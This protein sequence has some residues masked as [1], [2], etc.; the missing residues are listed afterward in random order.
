M[1]VVLVL[2]PH[3]PPSIPI[4]MENEYTMETNFML[5]IFFYAFRHKNSRGAGF[6]FYIYIDK[7]KKKKRTQESSEAKRDEML[8]F[9]DLALSNLV[10]SAQN[11]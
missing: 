10:F 7:K 6:E 11:Y 8:R 5:S 9:F 3:S 2:L 1:M 4:K